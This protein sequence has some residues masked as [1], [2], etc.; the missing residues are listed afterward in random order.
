MYLHEYVSSQWGMA[1]RLA[2]QLNVSP[3]MV[4]QWVAGT[5]Q[6]PAERCIEIEEL[7]NGLVTCEKLRPDLNWSVLRKPLNTNCSEKS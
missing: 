3:V 4:S 2:K 6:V 1:T 5:K 7:T